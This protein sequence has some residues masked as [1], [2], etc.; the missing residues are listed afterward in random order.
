M[1]YGKSLAAAILLLWAAF[2]LSAQTREINDDWLWATGA[3]GAGEDEAWCV[4]ADILGNLYVTG[5]FSGVATFGSHT[6]FAQSGTDVFVA[7]MSASGA[8]LWAYSLPS[9]GN[10]RGNSIC[11]DAWGNVIITGIFDTELQI[12]PGPTLVSFGGTDAFIA[13]F[14]PTGF[15]FW[16]IQV[17]GLGYETGT[18]VTVDSQ[19]N[20]YATGHFEGE[21]YFNTMY[22]WQSRTSLGES[23]LYAV[24][25]AE[26]GTIVWTSTA[27]GPNDDISNGIVVDQDGNSYVAGNFWGNPAFGTITLPNTGWWDAFAAKLDPNGNWLWASQSVGSGSEWCNGIAIDA[28]A[29]ICI[30]GG[31]DLD[32]SF[33]THQLVHLGVTYQDVF[34]AK[35]N[36]AG[37]WLWASSGGGI[38]QDWAYGI[39]VDDLANVYLTGIFDSATASFG[40]GILTNHGAADV[41]AAKLDPQ[42]NWLWPAQAGGLD[43]EWSHSVCAVQNGKVYLAGNFQSAAGFGTHALNTSG[44][45]DIFIAQLEGAP[46]PPVA[47]AP[48]NLSVSVL[49]G[50]RV[51]VNLTWDA[52]T[53]DME[54]NPVTPI[55]HLYQSL[56]PNTGFFPMATTTNS[57][58]IYLSIEIPAQCFFY[59]TAEAQP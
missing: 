52:V 39:A 40:D 4:T 41:F 1:P 17:S 45:Y 42:G 49:P 25:I 21:A 32:T 58:F 12:L 24:K 27:G 6:L 10:E 13:K 3:G 55:Y 2:G 15:C 19:G 26:P 29:N 51:E 22:G 48:Q 23:D 57:F 7:S 34:A 37:T 43:N 20:A 16:F 35:L 5:F 8:W 56:D 18:G 33:G 38:G 11:V 46:A 28:A 47:L 44:L 53:Q 9:Q 59:V 30:A 31:F 36:P 54:G 50:E 14:D